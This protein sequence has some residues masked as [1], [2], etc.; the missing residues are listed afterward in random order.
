MAVR[1]YTELIAWQKAMDLVEIVYRLSDRF[2]KDER[3]GLT[4]QLRRS[5]VSIPPNVAE[6]QG[7]WGT[8]E[9]VQFLG[10]AH[11]SL[12][13]LET[14]VHIAVRLGVVAV[15]DAGPAFRLATEVGKLIHGLRK[16]L[17]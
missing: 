15:E 11:G 16:S 12:C 10:I 6:G 17:C 5:A 7:R 2:P 3:F 1:S 4:A 14:Q 9:F 13:E 8:G